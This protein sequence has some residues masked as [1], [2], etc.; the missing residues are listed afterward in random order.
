MNFA[1]QSKWW[2][3]RKGTPSGVPS[4]PLPHGCHPERSEGS[5]YFAFA[6][7]CSLV[8]LTGCRTE[9]YDVVIHDRLLKIAGAQA[10]DCGRATTNDE[11]PQQSAC[12]LDHM[13][14]KRPFFV[15]Y[16][17]YGIDA[18]GEQGFSFDA[19]GNLVAVDTFSWGPAAPVGR[20]DVTGCDPRALH[21]STSG[22]LICY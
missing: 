20:I 16:Q 12:A 11:N 17:T 10:F 22:Y 4:T 21:K 8:C 19:K 5:P 1:H 9:P 2:H 13:A 3:K 18:I 15:Q 14:Q 6:V 7:V